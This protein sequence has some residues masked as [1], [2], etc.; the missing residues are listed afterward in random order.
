MP[1]HRTAITLKTH[2]AEPVPF[3]LFSAE[4]PRN[5]G[6]VGYNEK[7]SAK[8]GVVAKHA[9]KLMEALI[10]GRQTWTET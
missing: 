10:E 6:R 2:V 3:V 7:D 9:F 5:N 1:D 8:T 4:Q